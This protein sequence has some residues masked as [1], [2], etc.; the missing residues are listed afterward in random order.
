LD[1][2]KVLASP[3]SLRIA[4]TLV[5]KIRTEVLADLSSIDDL[6]AALLA[7]AWLPLGVK[8]TA[9]FRGERAIDGG[10]LTALPFRLALADDC[11]HILS[12]STRRMGTQSSTGS[13]L[14]TLTVRHLEKL[15]PGL[16]KGYLKA[17]EQ[18]RADQRRLQQARVSPADS[19]PF[20]LD[21][22]PLPETPDVKRHELRHQHLMD[23]ARTAYEVMYAATEGKAVSA[24]RSGA[25]RAVPRLTI[26]ERHNGDFAHIRLLDHSTRQSNPWGARRPG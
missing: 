16:G 12:L 13:L 26:A 19:G 4:L 1:Y 10:V 17:L 18:K 24:I 15:K 21:L 25:I 11:S 2:G 9:Y 7:S 6:R 3:S 14:H 8:G 20:I 23:A 22:A 5:D